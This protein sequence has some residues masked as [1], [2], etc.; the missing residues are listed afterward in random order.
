MVCQPS[1]WAEGSAAVGLIA[2]FGR[3]PGRVDVAQDLVEVVGAL[4]LEP[5]MPSMKA[6]L[7]S[8]GMTS[9]PSK[10]TPSLPVTASRSA[11][12][13]GRTW[14]SYTEV[15]TSGFGDRKN[16]PSSIW[17]SDHSGPRMNSS[18]ARTSGRSERAT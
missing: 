5:H 13:T 14:S 12:A 18:A 3:C 4:A 10:R 1:T 2:E 6:W 8:K 9:A 16:S 11:S 7:T 17:A 15:S